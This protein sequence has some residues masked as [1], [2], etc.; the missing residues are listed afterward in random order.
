[1]EETIQFL[2]QHNIEYTLHEHIAVF[3]CE[4]ADEH[5]GDIPGLACKN[6]L[7]RNRKKSRFF[8]LILP[9]D[10]QTDIK[11]FSLSVG[12]KNM[13]FANSDL[14]MAKLGLKPGS[15]SPFGLINDTENTVEVFI[16]R[17]VHEADIVTF[18][19]NVNTA[20]LELTKGMF[21]QYLDIVKQSVTI[22]D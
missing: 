4:E 2:A 17:K 8:L 7:I 15:V 13:S 6:L 12:E 16:H 3:T 20:T 19:P 22:I 1:M 10:M 14:L 11:N 9:N 5:C 21:H 18:H